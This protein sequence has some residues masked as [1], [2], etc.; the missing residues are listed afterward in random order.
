MR[1]FTQFVKSGR[2]TGGPAGDHSGSVDI[3]VRCISARA[4]PKLALGLAILFGGVSAFGTFPASVARIDSNQH[5]TRQ[6]GFVLQEQQQLGKGPGMQ[7]GTLLSPGLDPFADARKVFE[8]KSAPG[9]FSFGNDLLANSVVHPSSKTPLF[10]GELLQS[11]LGGTGLFLLKFSPQPA[12]PV[13]NGLHLRSGIAF[14]VRIGRN[15]NDAEIHPQKLCGLDGG[16]G[17]K[18]D[19][20]VQVELPIA[21]NQINLPFDAIKAFLLVFPVDQGHNQATFRQRPQADFIDSLKTEDPFVVG[22][23]SVWLEH[24]TL[25][26]VPAEA[27]YGFADSPYGHLGGQVKAGPDFSVSQ[28]MDRGLAENPG[29]ESTTGGEGSGLINALHRGEQPLALFCAGQELQLERQLHYSGVYHSYRETATTEKQS[30][31][32]AESLFLCQ[33]KQAVSE[34]QIL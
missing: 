4:T 15:V 29:L 13:A 32:H 6:G 10:A 14:S 33:L 21:I 11:P 1:T 2:F 23:G 24:R 3:G 12:M 17:W 31:L 8:F 27:F 9:A 20:A 34:A 22:D 28:F 30:A 18:I 19:R 16:V 7:N 25:A 5:H 26:F